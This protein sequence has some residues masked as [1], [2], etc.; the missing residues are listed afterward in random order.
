MT[1]VIGQTDKFVAGTLKRRQGSA[2]RVRKRRAAEARFKLF[3][4]AAISIAAA[5]LI[6]LLGSIVSKGYTAFGQ[7]NFKLSVFFDPARVDP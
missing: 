3:G 5:A 4:V 2:E 6:L 1:Q 7:T